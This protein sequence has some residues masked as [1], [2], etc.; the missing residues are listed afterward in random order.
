MSTATDNTGISARSGRETALD[1]RRALSQN[2]KAGMS[3]LK[4]PQRSR[5][6][7]DKPKSSLVVAEAVKEVEKIAKGGGCGCGCKGTAASG[8]ACG[9]SSQAEAKLDEVCAIVESASAGSEVSTARALCQERRQALSNRGKTALP[10][11]SLTRADVARVVAGNSSQTEA[12][13]DEV[14]AIVEAAPEGTPGISTARALCQERRQAL[15]TRGKTAL[16]KSSLTRADVERTVRPGAWKEAA[17]NGLSGREIARLRREELCRLGRGNQVICRPSGRVRPAVTEEAPAKVETFSTLRGQI[18]T[19]TRPERSR[20]VTGNEPGSCRAVTGTEYISSEQYEIFCGTRPASGA[21]KV[22]VTQTSRGERV[23]GTEVGRS[24]KV[25]GDETGSARAITGTEYLNLKESAEQASAAP[26]K[27]AVSHTARGGL[28]SGTVVGR[29][30]KVTGDERGG[31]TSV[32]GTEY[33]TA[34]QMKTFCATKPLAGPAKVAEMRSTAGQSVTGSEVGRSVKVTGDEAGSCRSLTGTQ[35]YTPE[36][37]GALC[38]KPGA[39]APGKVGLTH[40]L[41]DR[42]VTGTEV[43]RSVK[44]T[45]DEHGAC[46][47]VTGTEY[48]SAEQYQTV[49]ESKP[50][51]GAEKVGVSRT[52]HQQAVSGTQVGRSIKVTGDE[53]G[54][55]KPITGTE[56]I[57]AAQY[58][59]FCQPAE[60]AAARQ[61][62]RSI[63][64]TPGAALTGAQPGIGGKMTGDERG[65]CQ[66]VS[67]TPYVGA[68]QFA[69]QCKASTAPVHHRARSRVASPEPVVAEQGPAPGDFSIVTPARSAHARLSGRV[70]GTVYGSGGRVTGPVNLASGLISGTPEFRYSTE[71]AMAAAAPTPVRQGVTG[72][73]REAG[74]PITGDDWQRGSRVTGTEGMF[75]AGRNATLRG[76]ARGKP[77]VGARQFKEIEKP[78]IAQSR[79]TGSSGSASTGATITVSGGAR[80]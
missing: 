77:S 57:G 11:S 38:A 7:G 60:M 58:Q 41:R 47:P 62:V 8:T 75:S 74:S 22:G 46:K 53:Y 29:S 28:V 21:A 69:G 79:V 66:S 49:C 9:T 70:T 12:K 30:V 18:V 54:S 71:E 42:A 3:A 26:E 78:V 20:K 14:C 67:G 1:R 19:G 32:T 50:A 27:V 37:F 56:Y 31:C 25:T 45:G 63:S 16:P 13:L 34:E 64:G 6:S 73:G 33:L 52:W 76:E 17:A 59:E 48:I 39:G 61:R 23:T 72:E 51:P 10:K 15:S 40:T 35:Y 44:V 2:G 55:C 5:A 24:T 43:G 68:D 80:G 36:Q 65:A 4:S